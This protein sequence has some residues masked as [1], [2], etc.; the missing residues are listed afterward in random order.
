MSSVRQIEM[1][2]EHPIPTDEGQA[3]AL[4]DTNPQFDDVDEPLHPDELHATYKDVLA[5]NNEWRI[6]RVDMYGHSG[7]V[8]C[9]NHQL[10]YGVKFYDEDGSFRSLVEVMMRAAEEV[11]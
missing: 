2:G 7:Y 4:Q 11:A 10:G 9:W 8:Y 1:I 6:F 5:E 3:Y